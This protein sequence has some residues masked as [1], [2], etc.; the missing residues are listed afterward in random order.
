MCRKLQRFCQGVELEE[1]VRH[2]ALRFEQDLSNDSL[3]RK[4]AVRLR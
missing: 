3:G 4:F 1:P 2:N